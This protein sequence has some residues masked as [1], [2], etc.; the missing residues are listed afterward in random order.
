[1]V[2]DCPPVKGEARGVARRHIQRGGKLK[3]TLTLSLSLTTLTLTESVVQL[4]VAPEA[5]V[6][7]VL[8]DRVARGGEREL[9]EE[10]VR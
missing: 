7:V 8:E 10:F 9:G 3:L 5:D 1:M 4:G 6:L 2:A